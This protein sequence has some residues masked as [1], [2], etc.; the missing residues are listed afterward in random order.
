MQQI[1]V[2]I[3]TFQKSYSI[4]KIFLNKWE[5]RCCNTKRRIFFRYCANQCKKNNKKRERNHI[6]PWI[7]GERRA[8]VR[9]DSSRECRS[10]MSDWINRHD[11]SHYFIVSYLFHHSKIK[12]S[13]RSCGKPQA[14]LWS[15]MIDTPLLSHPPPPSLFLL[16]G[17]SLQASNSFGPRRCLPMI[18]D[19]GSV[20]A[21]RKPQQLLF[22]EPNQLTGLAL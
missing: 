19:L 15:L 3:I 20:C 9:E 21:Q 10:W 16:S 2:Y 1:L 12:G 4:A 22:P 14:L 5:S 8:G 13:L 6:F 11:N 7:K 18:K 17:S